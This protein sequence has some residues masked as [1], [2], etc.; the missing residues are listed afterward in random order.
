[1]AFKAAFLKAAMKTWKHWESSIQPCLLDQSN[2]EALKYCC[3]LLWLNDHYSHTWVI[4]GHVQWV[5]LICNIYIND[6]VQWLKW[7][8]KL[9]I[10]LSFNTID[11]DLRWIQAGVTS[12]WGPDIFTHVPSVSPWYHHF[13]GWKQQFSR[14]WLKIS[15]SNLDKTMFIPIII[16]HHVCWSKQV[17]I[18]MGTSFEIWWNMHL[19]K[20][21]MWLKQQ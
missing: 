16:Y 21:M 10:D 9:Q 20:A 2:S 4:L 19:F 12:R 15:R 8:C 11:I 1:M 6:H 17:N 14:C 13:C 7:T 5:I 18:D 3:G